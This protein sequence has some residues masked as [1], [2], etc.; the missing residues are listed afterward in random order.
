MTTAEQT[1]LELLETASRLER[2]LDREL[3]NTRGISFSEYRLLTRL[4]GAAAN[5]LPRSEL[6]R[7]VGLTA[8]AVTRALKPLEKL[9]YIESRRNDR[10]ARQSM[11]RITVAGVALQADAQNAVADVLGTLSLAHLPAQD[12][13]QLADCL[14]QLRRSL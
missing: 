12:L 2:R 10:D 9:G 14:L 1:T 7:A 13:E 3:A 11:T 5:G 4:H 6:A 8:S